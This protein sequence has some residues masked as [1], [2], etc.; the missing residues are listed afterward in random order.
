[1]WKLG[2]KNILRQCIF[3]SLYVKVTLFYLYWLSPCNI[4]TK[5]WLLLWFLFPVT[6]RTFG[7]KLF[8][9]LWLGLLSIKTSSEHSDVFLPEAHLPLF[10]K[11]RREI[12]R[13]WT[14]QR[15]LSALC[16]CEQ[17]C[18]ECLGCFFLRKTGW[19]KLSG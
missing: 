12:A 16:S 7:T 17:N 6:Y 5:K 11:K 4:W 18:P 2:D 15:S 13:L 14:G 9:H 3:K 8:C 19:L 10:L 1:M